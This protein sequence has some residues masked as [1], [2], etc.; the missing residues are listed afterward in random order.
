[1]LNNLIEYLTKFYLTLLQ[2]TLIVL[3]NSY[4]KNQESYKHIK[5]KCNKKK[6]NYNLHCS[7]FSVRRVHILR[8]KNFKIK[9]IN[10]N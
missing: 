6:L 2:K 4:L 8:N 3:Y 10:F 9:F 1:M 5:F 7:V